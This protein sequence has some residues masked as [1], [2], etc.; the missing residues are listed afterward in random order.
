MFKKKDTPKLALMYSG[1]LDSHIA[2]YMAKQKGYQVY[3]IYVDMGH[4][5]VHKEKAACYRNAPFHPDDLIIIHADNLIPT[6][7]A[8]GR[9]H[10]QIYPNRNVLLATIGSMFA[11]TVWINALKG[12]E[13]MTKYGER[14]DKSKAFFKQIT[15]LLTLTSATHQDKTVVESPFFNMTKADIIKWALDH[16]IPLQELFNTTSCYAAQ[17]KCGECV[18]CYKRYLAF[19]LNGFVEPGYKTNP[20]MSDYAKKVDFLYRSNDK[21]LS[22]SRREEYEQAI[23]KGIFK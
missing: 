17:G 23:A 20:F 12:E 13:I 10:D 18:T 22:P 7:K 15:K 5:Y 16:K 8:H 21:N 19:V 4:E 1:G 9:I 6:L 3:P 2:W 11:D 14:H